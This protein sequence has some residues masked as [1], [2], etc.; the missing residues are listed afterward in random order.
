[1]NKTSDAFDKECGAKGDRWK[2]AKG[3]LKA[4]VPL[5]LK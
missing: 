5:T 2:D 4:R 1:M 3:D